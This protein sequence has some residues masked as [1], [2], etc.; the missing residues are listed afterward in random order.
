MEVKDKRYHLMLD[1]REFL[2][3][4]YGLEEYLLNRIN[5]YWMNFS[6]SDFENGQGFE[7]NLFECATKTL[8]RADIYELF[9][10]EVK[11]IFNLKNSLNK[12]E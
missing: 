3:F 5:D 11:E 7:L 8:N 4:V 10:K 1:E 9:M 6:Q 12:A 2:A